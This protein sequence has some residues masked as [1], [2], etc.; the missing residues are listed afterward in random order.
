MQ[1]GIERILS[2][3]P[4]LTHLCPVYLECWVPEE[5]MDMDEFKLEYQVDFVLFVLASLS[6]TLQYVRLEHLHPSNDFSRWV[7]I[8]R[9][10]EGEYNRF[11]WVRPGEGLE[12]DV[13]VERWVD[14]YVGSGSRY[15]YP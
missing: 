5:L 13:N 4:N 8:K 3:C 6:P 12:K 7:I 10:E 15:L 9:T 14:C 11:D 1:S 2:L